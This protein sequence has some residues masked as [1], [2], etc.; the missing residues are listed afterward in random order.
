MWVRT[1][2]TFITT[3]STIAWKRRDI[4][5]GFDKKLSLALDLGCGEL[6]GILLDF[7]GSVLACANTTAGGDCGNFTPVPFMLLNANSGL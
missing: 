3:Y 6:D 4:E 5:E 7:K 2:V 1:K